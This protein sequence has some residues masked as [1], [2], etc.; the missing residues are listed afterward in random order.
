MRYLHSTALSKEELART[1]A[2]R[3][4]AAHR[5]HL[6]LRP[7]KG[8]HHYFY[9]QHAEFGLMHLRVTKCTLY[10]TTCGRR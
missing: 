2:E 7:G 1:L 4:H 6:E 10:L 5:L 3:D 9:F 8:L